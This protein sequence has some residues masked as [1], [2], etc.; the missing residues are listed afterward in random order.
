MKWDAAAHE[1]M[2]ICVMK[3]CE[4]SGPNLVKVLAD[5]HEKGYTF[6]ENAFR[7]EVSYQ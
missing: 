4:V 6:T 2:L 5:M 7:Y 3:H 1:D